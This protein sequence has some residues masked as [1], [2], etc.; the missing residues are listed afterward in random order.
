MTLSISEG[1]ILEDKYEILDLARRILA[2]HKPD[3]QDFVYPERMREVF[4]NV[5]RCNYINRFIFQRDFF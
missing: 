2:E 1:Q 4:Y 3:E 5:E